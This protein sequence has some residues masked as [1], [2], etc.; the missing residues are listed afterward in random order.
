[1]KPDTILDGFELLA[2]I[3]VGGFATIVAAILWLG[4]SVRRQFAHHDK[5][6]RAEVEKANRNFETIMLG[7]TYGPTSDVTPVPRGTSH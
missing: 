6:L 3:A 7:T 1:M 4:E 5:D 2:W